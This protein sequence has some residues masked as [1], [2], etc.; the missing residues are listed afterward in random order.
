MR[1]SFLSSGL[2]VLAVVMAAERADAQGKPAAPPRDTAA[3]VPSVPGMLPAS[4][5]PMPV[6]EDLLKTEPGGLTADQVGQRSMDTSFSAK[7]SLETMRAAE[8]RVD[9]AWAGFWPRLRMAGGRGG[10]SP[11]LVPHDAPWAIVDA[12]GAGGLPCETSTQGGKLPGGGRRGGNQ[13]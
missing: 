3:D 9:T 13:R 7:Q 4:T 11:G 12:P 8:A 1:I 6:P 10:A 2:V 5:T